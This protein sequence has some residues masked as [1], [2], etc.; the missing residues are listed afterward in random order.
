MIYEPTMTPPPPKTYFPVAETEPP[1]IPL[2]INPPITDT[3][4]SPSINIQYGNDILININY[5]V[6]SPSTAT[7]SSQIKITIKTP[8]PVLTVE[9]QSTPSFT[10]TLQLHQTPVTPVEIFAFPQKPS[11][12]IFKTP[13]ITVEID[14][15][16]PTATPGSP[17]ETPFESKLSSS[18]HPFTP[19]HSPHSPHSIPTD[20]M[21]SQFTPR[22]PRR[23]YRK[24]FARRTN[25]TISTPETHH[26]STSTQTS[27]D[28]A[29]VGISNH[30]KLHECT[31]TV[32]N[33]PKT[34][35]TYEE[36]PSPSRHTPSNLVAPPQSIVT[37]PPSS[38]ITTLPH[39]NILQYEIPFVQIP[40]ESPSEHSSIVE[41]RP[42]AHAV[43]MRTPIT[44]ITIP[45]IKNQYDQQSTKS[46]SPLCHSHPLLSEGIRIFMKHVFDLDYNANDNTLQDNSIYTMGDLSS[47]TIYSLLNG[48][49]INMTTVNIR[50]APW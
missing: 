16:R 48:R 35:L 15:H 26:P 4:L 12:L 28:P 7:P 41:I 46:P 14:T 43:E 17:V 18:A 36:T 5:H 23:P 44:H 38:Y 42:P 34:P 13:V 24:K 32:P 8:P 27:T 33:N 25:S 3:T 20:I 21:E 45:S 40:T 11:T 39:R 47:L 50:T 49:K 37:P 10:P 2:A 19:T 6:E 30:T 29:T 9:P 1:S 22:R 31:L